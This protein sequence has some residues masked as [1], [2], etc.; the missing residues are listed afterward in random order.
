MSGPASIAEVRREA[1]V[2]PQELL[3]A[4]D[5]ALMLF[6]AAFSGRNDC[7]WVEE[8][9]ITDVL[10]I[11]V[12]ARKL[13]TMREIYPAS[14]IFVCTD[15]F[16][17]AHVLK[18]G[19]ADLVCVD[20]FGGEDAEK[21]LSMLEDWCRL[22]RKFVVLTSIGQVEHDTPAGWTSRFIR[23]S[24]HLGGCYWLVLERA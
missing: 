22:A 23:R 15:A 7:V 8:A 10:A 20:A 1:S 6:C 18:A 2:F 9:G 17:A 12:D 19:Y 24:D 21:A 11:D 5:S 14:W 13:D 3:E 4:C 16:S